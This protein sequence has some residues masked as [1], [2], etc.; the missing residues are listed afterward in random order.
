MVVAGLVA[1]RSA[2]AGAAPGDPPAAL[3]AAARRDRALR[4]GDG[5]RARV[6]VERR[7][8]MS[9]AA[10]EA[11]TGLYGAA[12]RIFLVLAGDG[13][14]RS[15]ARRSP[16]LARAGRD[17]HDRLRV[18]VQRLFERARRSGAGLAIVDRGRG[19]GRDRRRRGRRLRAGVEPLRLARRR[20]A[21]VLRHR[22][23]VVRAAVA[24]PAAGAHRRQRGGARRVRRPRAGA[25]AGARRGGRRGR[26]ARRRDAHR[27]AVVR[28]AVARG[29]AAWRWAPCRG[30]RSP[31][32]P[33]PPPLLVPGLPALADA[34]LAAALFCG[35]ALALGLVPP[36]A[37]S[38]LVR[39]RSRRA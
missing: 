15:S 24:A 23:R 33:V 21:R 25:D 20:A 11:E 26:D 30:S 27:G 14:A 39:G 38:V 2:A 16:L 34:V 29:R 12:S 28:R 35:A 4:D 37:R 31:R 36:E 8:R 1:A 3:A 18:G 10:S 32:R 5:D 22:A 7:A 6:L 9:L 13:S 17:D 19:A